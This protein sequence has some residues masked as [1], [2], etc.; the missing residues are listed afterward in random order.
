MLRYVFTCIILGNGF[1]LPTSTN[2]LISTVLPNIATLAVGHCAVGAVHRYTCA[3]NKSNVSVLD[4]VL[5][6]TVLIALTLYSY[7]LPADKP[8][9][10]IAVATLPVDETIVVHTPPFVLRSI[11]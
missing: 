4:G 1:P 8:V 5:V 7:T 9:L 10:V 11:M 6:P 3:S 2:G